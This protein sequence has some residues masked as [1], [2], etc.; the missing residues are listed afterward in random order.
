METLAYRFSPGENDA[1]LALIAKRPRRIS[2]RLGGEI[3]RRERQ[4]LVMGSN[5][6]LSLGQMHRKLPSKFSHRASPHSAGLISH[7]STSERGGRGGR[8]V[9]GIGRRLG[10]V[11]SRRRYA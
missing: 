3:G 10:G 8:E 1:S 2:I 9:R 11:P 5:S 7:S 4:W 6:S